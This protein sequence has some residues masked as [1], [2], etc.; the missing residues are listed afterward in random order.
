MTDDELKGLFDAVRQDTTAIR[1][2]TSALR[3]DVTA[4]QED[5]R[6]IRREN[7]EAHEATRNEFRQTADRIAAET[8]RL[9]E[10]YAERLESR[11]DLVAE[12]AESIS[13]IVQ[14]RVGAVEAAIASS[15]AETRQ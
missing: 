7:A 2:E 9:F 1:Q 10:V 15:T 13:E 3:L 11:I 6:A 8:R 14:R 4:L 12:S 5:N